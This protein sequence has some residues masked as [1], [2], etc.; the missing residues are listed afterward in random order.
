MKLIKEK[1]ITLIITSIAILLPIVI[2]LIL[3]NRLPDTIATHFGADNEPNGWSSKAFTVFGL[4]A[5]M[6][7]MH[8]L[9]V[10]ASAAD[11]KSE[12]ISGR[13]WGI[14]LWIMPIVSV[15]TCSM[16]Y[17]YA[18]GV[19]V[20]VGF[21]CCLLIGFLFVILGNYLPKSRHNYSVGVRTRWTLNDP[22]NWN[23]T[24][25]IA[26]WIY[27]IGGFIIMLTSFLTSFLIVFGVA[28]VI[29]LVPAWCSYR[30]YVK[31]NRE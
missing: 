2:G 19:G 25:R 11:P 22:D 12:N 8:W 10:F 3:W 24:H 28:I 7:L 9:C 13:M 26:G 29:A 15:V 27:V 16:C 5:I 21:V 20:N 18:L 14:V 23:Y 30:Y 17:A 4:P 6:L 31:K 1:K